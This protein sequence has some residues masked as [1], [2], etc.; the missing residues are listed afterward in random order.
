LASRVIIGGVTLQRANHTALIATDLAAKFEER[1]RL[2]DQVDQ[3]I[4][5]IRRL[6]RRERNRKQQQLPRLSSLAER[7]KMIMRS[8]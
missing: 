4:A 3:A 6:V 1:R 7:A 5:E 8:A 2:L